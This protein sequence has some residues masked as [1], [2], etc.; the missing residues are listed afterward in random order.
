MSDM[1]GLESLFLKDTVNLRSPQDVELWTHTLD[2]YTAELVAAVTAVGN[3]P[4]RVLEYLQQHA[5]VGCRAG[6]PDP[7]PSSD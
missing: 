5:A 3:T 7:A 2:I 4:G 6:A 1:R